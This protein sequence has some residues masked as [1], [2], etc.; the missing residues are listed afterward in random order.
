MYSASVLGLHVQAQCL[1]LALLRFDISSMQ[2]EMPHAVKAIV[3]RKQSQGKGHVFA[4]A[5]VPQAFLGECMERA[6]SLL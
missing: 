6:H 4:H 2:N 5:D 3:S 1:I